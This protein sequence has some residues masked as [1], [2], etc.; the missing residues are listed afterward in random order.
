M[1]LNMQVKRNKDGSIKSRGIQWTDATWNPIA[2]CPHQCRWAMPDGQEAVCY[3]EDIAHGIAKS[4]YP[5]GFSAHYWKPQHLGSPKKVK[6]PLK[7]FV[8]SMSDIF[9]HRVPSEQIEQVLQVARDCPQHIFQFLTK[10]P[11]RSKDFDM[12][13]NVWL[14]ASMP[15]DHMW[16]NPLNMT[17]KIKML[18]KSLQSLREANASV[19]WMS[20]EP[21]SWHIRP[22][23]DEWIMFGTLDWAVIGAASRGSVYYPPSEH[24]FLS[25]QQL[26]THY[27][28][29]VFY[30]GNL[31]S[32]PAAQDN[33]LEQFPI[34]VVQ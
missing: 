8:G 33:W 13:D 12:P 26:L 17:Q 16:G 20:F 7:I 28:V 19:K 14:G 5:D 3:A 9:S 29:P 30:K 21:L 34:E 11:V 24:D 31:S 1:T 32:L 23:I 15:P 22:Y 18:V 6:E 10:N 4:A 27:R 25:L 2:G